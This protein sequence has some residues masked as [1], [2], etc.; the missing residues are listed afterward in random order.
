[1]RELIIV[2]LDK[3]GLYR[4]KAANKMALG[5]CSRSKD[6]IEP[7][8]R[9]QWYVDC[10]NMAKRAIDAVKN[11]EL[12]IEPAFHEATWYSWLTNIQDWCVSRQLWWGHRIP[13][14][15]VQF[16]G[17]AEITDDDAHWFTGRSE[18]EA[19]EK[20]E[21]SSGKKVISCKQDEVRTTTITA[22]RAHDGVGGT[23]SPRIGCVSDCVS[24]CWFVVVQDVL[25]TW[26]S[27]GLFPFSVMGWPKQTPDFEK[28]FP[29]SLLE[30]GHDIL[31][32]WVARMVMMSL[33]LTDKL[34]FHSVYLHAMVRDKFGRKMS[35]HTDTHISAQ[36]Q[37]QQQ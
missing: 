37:Q 1:M 30:T 22:S 9:P 18:A 33:E 28:F 11:K 26:F 4:G 29:G 34:P 32:F 35:V 15:I 8:L 6:V 27:S 16:E 13:A 23:I 10:Q 31:F 14:Y 36:Y 20:A 25:D 5:L 7:V 24:R 19:K 3:L 12:K 21:K 2:E 17:E